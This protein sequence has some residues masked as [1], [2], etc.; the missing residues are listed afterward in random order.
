MEVAMKRRT[1]YL[2]ICYD[3]LLTMGIPLNIAFVAAA[4]GVREWIS[5]RPMLILYGLLAFLYWTAVFVLGLANILVSFRKYGLGDD[6][7]CV[8]AMLIL[9]YGLVCFFILNFVA[10]C[11]IGLVALVG[12]RGTILLL[13][14]LLLPVFL[15]CVA[16]T[17]L[18][19]L[20]GSFYGVQVVRLSRM[21]GKLGRGAGETDARGN[22]ALLHG[23]LQFI[24][25]L[26]VLDA[27]YLAVTKWGM[28]KKS[29][30]LVGGLYAAFLSGIA[31]LFF[32]VAK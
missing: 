7:Y 6:R 31:V 13:F 17:W 15:F 14:P 32:F 24:F 19:M 30:V 5:Y 2:P 9:K 10:L 26:D 27:M 21:Q 4:V 3:C 1:Y 28:G 16:A 29:S 25:L 23:I 12:S 18:L 8:N 22:M 11:L 20:P